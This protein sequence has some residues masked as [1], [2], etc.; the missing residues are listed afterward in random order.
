MPPGYSVIRPSLD[1]DPRDPGLADA[2]DM[3]N[4]VNG[5]VFGVKGHNAVITGQTSVEQTP[6]GMGM[7]GHG[8]N[9]VGTVA[10]SA[11]LDMGTESYSI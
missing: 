10:D 8:I 4:P 2:W 7:R 6:L 9:G 5:T 11:D 1:V 3:G